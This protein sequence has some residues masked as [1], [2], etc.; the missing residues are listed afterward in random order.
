MTRSTPRKIYYLEN[1]NGQIVRALNWDTETL[2]FV[3]RSDTRRIESTPDLKAL[4]ENKIPFVLLDTV[5]K[6]SLAKT[7]RHQVTHIKGHLT[8][9]EDSAEVL[10]NVRLPEDN[11]KRF[12][13][14]LKKTTAVAFGIIC[15]LFTASFFI[16]SE[17]APKDELQIVQ[18]LD[19]KKIAPPTPMVV[20]PSE[21]K[22]VHKKTVSARKIV[23]RH[24]IQV[25]RRVQPIQQQGALAVLGQL[26]SSS[27]KGGLQLSKLPSSPGIGNGGTRGSGGV[28]TA[29]YAKGLF[30]A[31]VGTGNRAD[32]AGG[33]GTKGKGGGNKGFGKISL[34]GAASSFFEP[35]E[36][37]AWV[38]GGLDRNEI[39]AVIQRH[40]SEVR[41][42]YEQG[43]QQKPGLAG[44]VSMK[45]MIGS[46]GIVTTAQINNSSLQH[47]MVENCIRS[48]LMTWKFPQPEGGVTVKVSYPFVLR[49]VS[50]LGG[51]NEG[52]S[53]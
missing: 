50:S 10:A 28:Q 15:I 11:S 26:K 5:T 12:A 45:F 41:Y 9:V 24:S 31:P 49:R 36:S 33:Y 37:E 6:A 16:H 40:L 32:G 22:M 27:Q 18:V 21:K 1:E 13:D 43:L 7:S 8:L 38:E 2:Y 14:I 42:C 51:S 39:A 3:Y 34:S 52:S 48:K 29:V 17:T 19:R 25:K 47:P 46:R 4:E 20:T 44:R 30:A 23:K 53:I 35:I